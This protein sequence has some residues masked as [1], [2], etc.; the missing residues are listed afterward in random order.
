MRNIGGMDG[1]AISVGNVLPNRAAMIVYC[2]KHDLQQINAQGV[3][4]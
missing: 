3:D 2:A 4:H 1:F